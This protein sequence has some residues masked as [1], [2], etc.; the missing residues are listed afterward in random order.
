[1]P[2]GTWPLAKTWQFLAV[3]VLALIEDF[4][5]FC[6]R[7]SSMFCC[8]LRNMKIQ[9]DLHGLTTEILTVRSLQKPL[10]QSHH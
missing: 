8:L 5:F 2:V 3:T 10:V 1:M 4:S 9:V 6:P 7:G